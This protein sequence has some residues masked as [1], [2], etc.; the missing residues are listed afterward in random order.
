MA[1]MLNQRDQLGVLS[2]LM[3]NQGETYIVTNKGT[4]GEKL[5]VPELPGLLVVEQER[6]D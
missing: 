6:L 5:K 3:V 4:V 2:P 1:V